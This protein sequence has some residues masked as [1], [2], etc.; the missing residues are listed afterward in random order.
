MALTFT[1]CASD[2]WSQ[3]FSS[4]YRTDMD[5][6]AKVDDDRQDDIGLLNRFLNQSVLNW[7]TTYFEGKTYQEILN[8]AKEWHQRFEEALTVKA[9]EGSHVEDSTSGKP[10]AVVFLLEV[11]N[12]TP[13]AILGYAGKIQLR[14]QGH[15]NP[16]EVSSQ[17]LQ[18]IPG[19]SSFRTTVEYTYVDVV[20]SFRKN[21]SDQPSVSYEVGIM[22]D[23]FSLPDEKVLERF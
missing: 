9:I 18:N 12:T 23:F 15:D 8:E 19:N 10:P 3:E 16:F 7:A 21:G 5:S 14:I 2:F 22:I 1:G 17:R 13:D 11:T 4:G 6:Q 20:E